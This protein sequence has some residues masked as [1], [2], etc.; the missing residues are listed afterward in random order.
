MALVLLTF[1]VP[2]YKNDDEFNIFSLLKYKFDMTYKSCPVKS[3][4]HK[5][6]NDTL[7]VL[8]FDWSVCEKDAGKGEDKMAKVA[9]TT[10]D[11]VCLPFEKL[12]TKCDPDSV[13]T[14][15]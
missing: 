14:C 7:Q 10:E 9:I 11:L 8:Q 6:M 12:M 3:L 2:W 13:T 4:S 1:S 15:E 5:L